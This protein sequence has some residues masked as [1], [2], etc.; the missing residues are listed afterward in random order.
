[1]LVAIF[2]LME[3]RSRGSTA[4]DSESEEA[5]VEDHGPLLAAPA[6]EEKTAAMERIKESTKKNLQY[7]REN[8]RK[9]AAAVM[10]WLSF[11]IATMSFSLLGPFF[12]QEV[13]ML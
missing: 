4:D 6:T 12:P 9:L 8:K 7:I 2:G 5:E 11:L 10:L 1:M 13:I 3:L